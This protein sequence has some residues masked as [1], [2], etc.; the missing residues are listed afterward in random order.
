MDVS[1]N[2]EIKRLKPIS[3]LLTMKEFR[4]KC[5]IFPMMITGCLLS[6]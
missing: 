1:N 6:F 5:F 2:E 3:V 4:V